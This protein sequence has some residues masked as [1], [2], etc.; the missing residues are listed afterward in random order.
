MPLLKARALTCQESKEAYADARKPNK[1]PTN[2]T[3][4]IRKCNQPQILHFIYIFPLSELPVG[5]PNGIYFA[6]FTFSV[7]E[8]CLYLLEAAWDFPLCVTVVREKC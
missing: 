1:V 5:E 8:A 7:L 6:N 2:F 4:V 3:R